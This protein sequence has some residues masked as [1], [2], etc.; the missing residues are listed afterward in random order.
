M[1][2]L[3]TQGDI[4]NFKKAQKERILSA[5]NH[6]EDKSAKLVTKEEFEKACPTDQFE[7]YTLKKIDQFRNDLKKAEDVSDPDAVFKAACADLKP[8]LVVHEGK[9]DVVFTR[10]KSA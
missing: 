5:F 10:K 2:H 9:R 8:W 7:I 6:E 1:I 4:D 3:S